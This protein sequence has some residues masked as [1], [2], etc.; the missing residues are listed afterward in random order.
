MKTAPLSALPAALAAL[1]LAAFSAGCSDDGGNGPSNSEPALSSG[2]GSS[3]SGSGERA[4]FSPA[5]YCFL[6]PD[7]RESM[8]IA[9]CAAL[10]GEQ[11]AEFEG[12]YEASGKAEGRWWNVYAQCSVRLEVDVALPCSADSIAALR[13]CSDDGCPEAL[14]ACMADVP[15]LSAALPCDFGT[16]Q[17]FRACQAASGCSAAW[18]SQ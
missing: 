2:A 1:A 11:R 18:F 16:V 17:Y 6:N 13:K 14:E 4:E 8:G 10:T 3:S 12:H 15:A 5:E 7:L 9:D